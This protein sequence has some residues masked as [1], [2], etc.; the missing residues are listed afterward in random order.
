MA[1][2]SQKSGEQAM[3]EILIGVTENCVSERKTSEKVRNTLV[4]SIAANIFD[5]LKCNDDI[6]QILVGVLDPS[7]TD[8]DALMKNLMSTVNSTLQDSLL[9]NTRGCSL[10][11]DC[12]S[13]GNSDSMRSSTISSSSVSSSHTPGIEKSPRQYDGFETAESDF[14]YES[15]CS[16]ATK[17]YE[18]GKHVN[19]YEVPLTVHE[20]SK[21]ICVP[22]S[23]E[24]LGRSQ[25]LEAKLSNS[26]Q[27]TSTSSRKEQTTSRYANTPDLGTTSIPI[28]RT[29]GPKQTIPVQ[30]TTNH[31]LQVNKV[32]SLP[33][34]PRSQSATFYHERKAETT[35]EFKTTAFSRMNEIT[36]V[37]VMEPLEVKIKTAPQK[38][39]LNFTPDETNHNLQQTENRTN[40][41]KIENEKYEN[42]HC[43]QQEE[44]FKNITKPSQSHG[45]SK[46]A[47]FSNNSFQGKNVMNLPQNTRKNMKHQESLLAQGEEKL[48][49][50]TECEMQNEYQCSSSLSNTLNKTSQ[51]TVIKDTIRAPPPQIVI[52]KEEHITG[53]GLQDS[54]VGDDETSECRQEHRSDSRQSQRSLSPLSVGPIPSPIDPVQE[55]KAQETFDKLYEKMKNNGEVAVGEVIQSARH[56]SETI[57]FDNRNETQIH[58]TEAKVHIIP[59]SLVDKTDNTE[60]FTDID[61]TDTNQVTSKTD[62][63]HINEESIKDTMN[64]INKFEQNGGEAEIKKKTLDK[65]EE[66]NLKDYKS[67]ETKEIK[68]LCVES[69]LP[70]LEDPS[71][72]LLSPTPLKRSSSSVIGSYISS[73]NTENL[74]SEDDHAELEFLAEEVKNIKEDK[75]ASYLHEKLKD[76]I[77]DMIAYEK[78]NCKDDTQ[79]AGKPINHF[80][81]LKQKQQETQKEFHKKLFNELQKEVGETKNSAV[82]EALGTKFEIKV[83]PKQESLPQQ[84]SKLSHSMST[85]QIYETNEQKQGSLSVPSKSPD[86]SRRGSFSNTYMSKG[87]F[88]SNSLPRNKRRVTFDDEVPQRPPPPAPVRQQSIHTMKD[89]TNVTQNYNQTLQERKHQILNPQ[90][91]IKEQ[92]Q[93]KPVP[94]PDHADQT[95]LNN[96]QSVEYRSYSKTRQLSSSRNE[97]DYKLDL[98]DRPDPWVELYGNSV[99]NN[100]LQDRIEQHKLQ[101]SQSAVWNGASSINKIIEHAPVAATDKLEKPKKVDPPDFINV[102]SCEPNSSTLPRLSSYSIVP[103]TQQA[104]LRRNSSMSDLSSQSTLKSQYTNTNQSTPSRASHSEPHSETLFQVPPNI[105]RGIVITV[106]QNQGIT[107][108]SDEILNKAIQEYYSK[109]PQGVFVKPS[110]VKENIPTQPLNGQYEESY[111]EDFQEKVHSQPYRTSPL[112]TPAPRTITEAGTSYQQFKGP[113]FNPM[114]RRHTKNVPVYLRGAS[115]MSN[116]SAPDSHNS[117]EATSYQERTTSA[118]NSPKTH[119]RMSDKIFIR[120]PDTFSNYKSSVCKQG[121]L[122]TEDQDLMKNNS[123]NQSKSF[124]RVMADLLEPGATEF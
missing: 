11:S 88:W 87:A 74:T 19:E 1:E 75:A 78:H 101:K 112:V 89:F 83:A 62:S 107:N 9:R 47:T 120:Q 7:R 26:D 95:S 122:D 81:E 56:S 42:T 55:E 105:V 4:N 21:S 69:K 119:I 97:D 76:N 54:R 63:K 71:V 25:Q 43:M 29:C 28:S 70:P 33:P 23:V 12:L 86:L 73:S 117:S 124:K 99:L 84:S 30:I 100:T 45:I 20:L 36:D 50:S 49:S 44:Y 39:N 6:A 111:G 48:K 110:P 72:I 31:N 51:N 14:V 103:G 34:L 17:K 109:N 94:L 96:L 64:K 79:A 108:P 32:T 67:N 5:T 115:S 58:E 2:N 22:I 61:K 93:T 46:S 35:K 8:K 102:S 82:A 121:S 57:C 85:N 24:A 13:P 106:L 80:C 3:K 38:Q 77:S 90:A 66:V 18:M 16:M 118:Q 104:H 123:I 92:E 114:A 91:L 40:V 15:S 37:A 113:Q 41:A 53:F 68:N 116:L 52:G 10:N 65:R 27:T 60:A 59:I 98:G